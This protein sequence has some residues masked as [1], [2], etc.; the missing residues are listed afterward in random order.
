M[1]NMEI[2]HSSFIFSAESRVVFPS[3]AHSQFNIHLKNQLVTHESKY[4]ESGNLTNWTANG[5]Q[6]RTESEIQWWFANLNAPQWILDKNVALGQSWYW[7]LSCL[8]RQCFGFVLTF[9]PPEGLQLGARWAHRKWGSDSEACPMSL[10][11]LGAARLSTNHRKSRWIVKAEECTAE[12]SFT[13]ILSNAI[14]SHQ[15]WLFLVSNC[16]TAQRKQFFLIKMLKPLTPTWVLMVFSLISRPP[17]LSPP[18]I[19]AHQCEHGKLVCLSLFFYTC[20][21]CMVTVNV[22]W[23]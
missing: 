21:P 23:P 3:V 5:L 1:N 20:F 22:D 10:S 12:G 13:P 14:P 4:S 6:G 18:S 2:A 7:G 16:A 19:Y 15:C 17:S 11:R 9:W 8:W